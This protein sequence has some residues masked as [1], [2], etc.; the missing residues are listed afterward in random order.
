MSK[1]GNLFLLIKSLSKSEKRYF[2]LYASGNDDANYLQL[3]D[4]IDAQEEFDEK[5][6]K[7]QFRGKAFIRQLHVAKIYLSDMILKSL[8]NYYANESVTSQVLDLIRDT[9]ILYRKELYDASWLKIEKAEKLAVKFEKITL[10]MEILAW[11][12]KLA[13]VI[14]SG[15]TAIHKILDI[16]KSAIDK[17]DE[18]NQYWFKTYN[19]FEAVKKR[20][21]LKELALQKTSTLQSVTL[22][23]HLLYSYYF[24]NGETSKAEK[25]ITLLIRALEDH[26]ERIGEDPGSYVTALGNKI[27]LLLYQ[28]KW[29]ETEKMIK[30]MRDVPSKYKLTSK[31][32]FTV[33]LWLRI[34]NLELEVYRDTRQLAKGVQLI[35]EAEHYLVMHKKIIPDNYRIM[36]YYQFACI[37]FLDT[38]YSRSLYWI[39]AIVNYNFGEIRNELQCY[40]RIMNLMV[41]FEL[42]NILVL[43]YAVDSCRRFFKKKKY[44]HPFGQKTLLMFSRLSLALPEDYPGI[45]ERS[46][47]DLFNK[48]TKVAEEAKDYI[49]MEA[50]IKS[51]LII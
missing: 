48:N 13:V 30:N 46:Y 2:K 50:W 12:K 16:E 37:Y 35:S 25:E 24:M 14:Q 43:R 17:L 40:A 44:I 29:D 7:D 18:L 33:R 3:F 27:G 20:S 23:K 1:K 26:P 36:L 5:V 34:F 11:K 45:F 10:F 21:F 4:A 39:N 41:H 6:L 22:H 42:Q 51:K 8:R 47:N 31:N 15:G 38:N 28:K 49:D 19:L 32:Q 9:E